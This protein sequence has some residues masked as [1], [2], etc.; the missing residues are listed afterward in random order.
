MRSSAERE[1]NSLSSSWAKASSEPGAAG[2]LEI[3]ASRAPAVPLLVVVPAAVAAVS[4]ASAPEFGFGS[5]FI[6]IPLQIVHG[7]GFQLLLGFFGDLGQR[8]RF[9]LLIDEFAPLLEQ[10]ME[11]GRDRFRAAF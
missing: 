8:H 5:G 10:A 3:G 11:Q 4:A 7:Y 6:L 9:Q 2:A 1:A